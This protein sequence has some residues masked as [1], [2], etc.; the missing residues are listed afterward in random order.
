M[1]NA[2]KAKG[3]PATARGKLSLKKETVKDLSVRKAP[4]GGTTVCAVAMRSASIITSG[5]RLIGDPGF[6]PR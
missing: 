1:S 4:R 2:K 6:A 5:G 3:K